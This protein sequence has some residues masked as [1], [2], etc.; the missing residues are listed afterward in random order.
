MNNN[1][2]K[3]YK[4]FLSK[5]M[6]LQECL[7]DLNL[8]CHNKLLGYLDLNYGYGEINPLIQNILREQNFIENLVDL[9]IKIYP[10]YE[11]LKEVHNKN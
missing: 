10:N 1:K 9:L 4:T 8:F 2:D 6:S 7:N 3:A 5:T 11:N